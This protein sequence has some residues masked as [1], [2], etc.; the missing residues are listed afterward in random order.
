MN[1][2]DLTQILNGHSRRYIHLSV[3]NSV[4]KPRAKIDANT[5]LNRLCLFQAEGASV[6]N[7]K[8]VQEYSK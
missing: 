3:K 2:S 5:D 4:S 1:N 6:R 7:V 8:T